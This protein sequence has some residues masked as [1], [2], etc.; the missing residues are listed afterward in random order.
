MRDS[1]ASAQAVSLPNADCD[2]FP[3]PPRGRP[4]VLRRRRSY[5]CAMS[6][7]PESSDR[8][9][10]FPPHATEPWAYQLPSP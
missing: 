8:D 5:R 7:W 6:R 4:V 10:F 9:A 2:L 3:R 1:R